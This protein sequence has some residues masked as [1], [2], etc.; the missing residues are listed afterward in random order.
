MII[1]DS[2]N[3]EK[4]KHLFLYYGLLQQKDVFKSV[5]DKNA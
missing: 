2:Q 5:N 3:L 4:K 1:Q